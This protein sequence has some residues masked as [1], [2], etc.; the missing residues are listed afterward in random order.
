MAVFLITLLVVALLVLVLVFGD[1]PAFRNTPLQ[2]VY[3]L[4]IVINGKVFHYATA[5]PSLYA[6]IRW[7]APIGYCIV[8]GVCLFQFFSH[9]YPK[10][11]LQNAP[12]HSLY[13]ILSIALIILTT[14]LLTFSNPGFADA[15]TVDDAVS[16]YPANNLIFF[17]GKKCPTCQLPKPARSKHCSVCNRCVY[18]YDHH[19]IFVNNCVG[20]KNY[21]WFI[22]FLASNVNFLL[23]GAYLCRM[24]LV[25]QPRDNGWWALVTRTTQANKVA[26][27]LFLLASIFS[28]MV[29]LFTALHFRYMY[30]GVTTNEADKWGEIEHLV[31]L[32]LLYQVEE[33]GVYVEQATVR[34]DN[35][36]FSQV[37]I[38][39]DN[40]RILFSDSDLAKKQCALRKIASV[41]TD[42]ENIYDRGFVEN[43]KSRLFG[44]SD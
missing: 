23:Y 10:L 35:G 26:G 4:L 38:S 20:E 31:S 8:V 1:S 32:G 33:T 5:S 3:R 39:L 36:A 40:Q 42:L 9:V 13:I 30:L 22:A 19:C 27:T 6:A 44:M 43:M 11:D 2:K 7:T 12:G 16:K 41:N 17:S 34:D 18:L 24:L 29:F 28:V 21:R 37:Y 25:T 15:G 14:E